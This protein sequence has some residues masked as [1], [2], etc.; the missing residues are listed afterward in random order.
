MRTRESSG[1]SIYGAQLE[2]SLD[3][4]CPIFWWYWS[5][6]PCSLPPCLWLHLPRAA[7][8]PWSLLVQTCFPAHGT[9]LLTLFDYT[10]SK[11]HLQEALD[12]NE[13][14]HIDFS[15]KLMQKTTRCCNKHDCY[16]T[17]KRLIMAT[18]NLVELTGNPV[19]IQPSTKTETAGSSS[20]SIATTDS[21]KDETGEW[22]ERP[23]SGI[24]FSPLSDNAKKYQFHQKAAS[25]W[26]APAI[27]GSPCRGLTPV[28]EAA[29]NARREPA[30]LMKKGAKRHGHGSPRQ[31]EFAGSNA[32]ADDEIPF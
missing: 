26:P 8:A 12:R 29:I 25:R 15:V 17:W 28:R 1:P 6:A 9:P 3:S 2:A 14:K 20:A 24:L 21:W 31:V 13:K 7:P 32:S 27:S 19:P 11:N 4:S 16:A 22:V 5:N 23:P 18:N 10:S 30:P